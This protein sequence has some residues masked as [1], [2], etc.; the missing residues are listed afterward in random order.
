VPIDFPNPSLGVVHKAATL[1]RRFHA[2]IV[3]LHVVTPDSHA[4]GVP[5]DGPE[6]AGWDIVAEIVRAA[7]KDLDESLG[8]ELEDLAIQRVLVKGDPAHAIVTTA[9]EGKADLIMMPSHGYT[10]DQFLLGSVTAKILSRTE[11]PVWTGAH[12]E[13]SPVQDFALRNI[14]CAVDF[15]ARSHKTLSWSAGIAAEFGA[16]LTLAHVNASVEIWGPGGNYINPEWKE[17]MFS[18]ASQHLAKLQQ[19]VHQSGRPDRHR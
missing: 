5:N 10:F 16:H 3:M 17:A 1:A 2:E 8:P 11:C 7:Q 13:K 14:L 15:G 4:A 9:Q 12:V 19:D 18:D 6:G